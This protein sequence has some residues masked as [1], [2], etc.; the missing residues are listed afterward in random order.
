[1]NRRIVES[2]DL[3]V[4]MASEHR[5]AVKR[6]APNAAGRAFT[7]KE[8]VYLLVS[9]GS[10]EGGLRESACDRPASR[11]IWFV[12]I[13]PSSSRTKTSRTPWAWGSETFRAIAWEIGSLSEALVDA[14][15]ASDGHGEEKERGRC[16]ERGP[17]QEPERRVSRKGGMP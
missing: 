14:V 17:E 8:L 9:A 16:R 12:D 7:L 2:A 4:G 5:E 10:P 6:I 1:M 11:P 3:I 13:R 15:F